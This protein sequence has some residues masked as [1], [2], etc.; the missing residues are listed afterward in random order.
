M[1]RTK[2]NIQTVSGLTANSKGERNNV[3]NIGNAVNNIRCRTDYRVLNRNGNSWQFTSAQGLISEISSD[4][5]RILQT[6][7]SATN[8]YIQTEEKIVREGTNVGGI[9]PKYR[10]GGAISANRMLFDGTYNRS[11][12]GAIGA[13]VPVGNNINAAWKSVAML[14]MLKTPNNIKESGT[15]QNSSTNNIE[16]YLKKIAKAGLD[17]VGKAGEYGKACSLP[18]E[19]VKN[20]I[21]G[22][23]ITGKDIGS[24]IKGMGNSIIGMGSVYDK[25]PGGTPLSTDDIKSLA[26]LA[27][28]KTISL[29]SQKAGWI[30]RLEN[31]GT[32]AWSTLK[33]EI[34]PIAKSQ[35]S[36]GTEVVD[37][38][39]TGT[40]V[41]G[42][43]LSLIA[44]GFSN[45][46]EYS[47]GEIS[48]GRAVAETVTETVI[49]IGK[50]AAIAAGVAA[51]CAAIGFAAPAVVVSGI[52]IGVS[53]V[54]DIVCENL[55]GKSINEF[56]SDKILD[57]ASD[58]G[59]EISGA[60]GKAGKA[61]SGWMNKVTSNIGLQFAGAW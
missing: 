15:S 46:D 27:T 18:I 21:D 16:K 58:V 49:D 5:G 42:W 32:S 2:I 61:I 41:A 50:K 31:S 30:G 45:Y 59:K 28:Y 20:I 7:E 44:N 11:K 55:T 53:L 13:G 8:L 36:D 19:I 14:S 29:A 39:K 56:A 17:V 35:L 48:S 1:P 24:V 3:A 52:G 47:K 60:V 12:F 37:T 10:G 34:S 57:F 23:G 40:K 33:K 26:G 25:N 38:V 51:G 22:D 9:A 6:I 4:I 43:A 54:A